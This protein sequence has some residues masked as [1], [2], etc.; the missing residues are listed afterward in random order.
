M[1]K[2]KISVIGVGYVGLCTAVGFASKGY[3][4]VASDVDAEKIRKIC[5]GIPPFY[6]PGL[7]ELLKETIEN[8]NLQCSVNET[9]K[10]VLGTDIT[11]IAVNSS[12]VTRMAYKSQIC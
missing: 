1:T 2:P 12:P 11:Y 6:E 7:S 8:G 5:A 4:V 3:Q 10:A 9:Q